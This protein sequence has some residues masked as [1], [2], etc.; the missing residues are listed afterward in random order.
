MMRG[1][2]DN[3]IPKAQLKGRFLDVPDRAFQRAF[4]DAVKESGALAWSAPGRRPKKP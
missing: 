4:T 2:P 1:D 3:P